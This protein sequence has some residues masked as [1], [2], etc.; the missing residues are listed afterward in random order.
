MPRNSG[1]FADPRGSIVIDDAKTFFAAHD[2]RYDL[3]VSA[4]STP[5]VS[6]VASLFTREFYRRIR[7][8][9]EPGGLLAQWFQLYEID[10]SLVATVMRALGEV[11]PHYAVFAPSD[12]DLLI[13]AGER[14]VPMPPLA[15]VFEQPGVAKELWTVHVLTAGGLAGRPPRHPAPPGP[16]VA[17][18]PHA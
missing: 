16:P 15:R 11:F 6:G 7:T 18:H 10:A 13:V 14:P 9:L 3:I 5:W 4:P 17:S 2:R 8:H 12:H 1:A